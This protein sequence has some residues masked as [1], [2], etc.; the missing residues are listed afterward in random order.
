MWQ[1]FSCVLIKCLTNRF[2]EHTQMTAFALQIIFFFWTLNCPFPSV[3][4]AGQVMVNG[5]PSPFSKEW[6]KKKNNNNNKKI[7]IAKLRH[8]YLTEQKSKCTSD[9]LQNSH[10]QHHFC[11]RPFCIEILGHMSATLQWKLCQKRFL[12]ILQNF[13]T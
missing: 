11:W 5:L 6:K 9:I 2:T 4:L 1:F 12:R 13:W 3:Q 10:S 7:N 8:R